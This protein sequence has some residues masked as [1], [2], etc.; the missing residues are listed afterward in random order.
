MTATA[1]RRWAGDLERRIVA[2]MSLEAASLAVMSSLH[3][4]GTLAGGSK[5][6]EPSDAGI[7]EA[8]ICLAL[9]AGT[10]A[11]QRRWP[12]GGG[13]ALGTVAF[14]I[15]GFLVGL[16]FTVQGG[17]AIDIAYHASVLPLLVLTLAALLR[18]L[19]ARQAP[20]AESGT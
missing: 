3:L 2:L 13:I 12:N 8:L 15:L 9:I 20:P 16:N 7:A 17:D 10:V 18:R 19:S 14:A 6:F 5:P 1:H 11:F 4:T